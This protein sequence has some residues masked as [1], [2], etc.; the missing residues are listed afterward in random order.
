MFC[1]LFNIEEIDFFSH[2][3]TAILGLDL[4]YE[5]PQ[6]QSDT[7]QLVGL[8]WTNDRPVAETYTEQITTL[9]RYIPPWPAGFKLAFPTSKWPQTHALDGAVTGI[10]EHIIIVPEIT[11]SKVFCRYEQQRKCQGRQTCVAEFDSL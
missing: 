8:L 11:V 2:S 9:K 1:T 5:V 4:L 3:S 7:P 6:S 10:G